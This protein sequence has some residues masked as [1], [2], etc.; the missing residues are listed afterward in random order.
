VVVGAGAGA[1][2]AG[3]AAAE[4]LREDGFTGQ[5][6][7]VGA[8]VQRDPGGVGREPQMSSS[9][10]AGDAGADGKQP[11]PQSFRLPSSG[12][13]VGQGEHLEPGGEFHGQGDDR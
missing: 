8:E 6:H 5:L 2:A 13:V 12:V 7:L 1:G 10:M 11:E 3:N 4:R 9:G